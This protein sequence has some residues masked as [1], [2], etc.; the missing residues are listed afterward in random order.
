MT[1]SGR[2]RRPAR[3]GRPFRRGWTGC[4]GR[5]GTGWC[6]SGWARCAVLGSLVF[7]YLTDRFGR[8][9]LFLL[10]LVLYLIATVL[11][12]FSF[13]SGLLLVGTAALFGNGALSATGL[14]LAW[15][16]VF[17]F[18]SAGASAA[19]LTVLEIFPME[20]RAMAIALFYS[21][22]TGLGGIIG[23]SLFGAL[24]ETGDPAWPSWCSGWRP[25]ASPW[26]RWR[27]RCRQ[28][29]PGVQPKRRRISAVSQTPMPGNGCALITPSGHYFDALTT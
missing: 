11:T 21:V 16:A 5:A 2:G 15:S 8:K 10:T 19:Y 4:R 13:G 25:P 22:G 18:A 9:K 23:P 28:R 3:W 24:V 1:S 6:C 20:I 17:F 12:A 26:S 14:P 29:K 7:S 27:G